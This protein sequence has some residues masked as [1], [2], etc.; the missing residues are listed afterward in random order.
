M[1]IGSKKPKIKGTP[2]WW[3]NTY[4]K[5]KGITKHIFFSLSFICLST[6]K[7]KIGKSLRRQGKRKN[8]A[9]AFLPLIVLRYIFSL[10]YVF[11]LLNI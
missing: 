10:A 5:G 1:V 7:E 9:Q 3:R 8:I 6:T 11:A 2:L 4:G